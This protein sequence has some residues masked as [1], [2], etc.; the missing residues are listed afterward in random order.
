[1]VVADMVWCGVELKNGTLSILAA[2]A[3]RQEE[4]RDEYDIRQEILAEERKISARNKHSCCRSSS[5]A[6]SGLIFQDFF[7]KPPSLRF[8][9]IVEKCLARS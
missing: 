6:G 1:M 7:Q 2:R 4:L 9:G 5:I 3:T 8:G